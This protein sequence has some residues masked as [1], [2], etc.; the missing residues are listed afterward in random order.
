MT[1]YSLQM[2]TLRGF[3]KSPEA[4]DNTLSRVAEMGYKNV[5]I[6]PPAFT[7]SVELAKL[8]KTKGLKA[9]SAICGVYD[10]PYKIEQIAKGAEAL[11][12]DVLRTDS[13]SAEDRKTEEGYSRF[14]KHLNSCGKMLREKG[15]DFM[16]HF[17]SFEF[18]DFG[19][20]RGIDILLNETDPEYVMF[21]P[22]VFWL[23]AAGTEPSRALKMF[24]GRVRYMHC[25]DY[26]IAAS[27]DP[28]LEK[29][30]NASAPVGTGN[31]HWDEIFK[32]AKELGI[33][34]FVVE[35]DMGVLDPFLSAEISL[36]NLKKLDH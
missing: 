9:D 35:D 31:L 36:K 8:L 34:N 15:L 2:F 18:I 1:Q 21:Q 32:S 10:I 4:L 5:Q 29:I 24:K 16:Y 30:T 25:K 6:T 7:D 11:G 26:I 23:A 19:G 20:K 13:I 27:A 17:H 28:K 12:T 3:M 22:D 14:A 33:N